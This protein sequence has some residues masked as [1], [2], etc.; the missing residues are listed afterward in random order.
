MDNDLLKK[1]GFIV[2]DN[3]L[4][5]GYPYLPETT[6]ESEPSGWA[7]KTCNEFVSADP[8]VRCVSIQCYKLPYSF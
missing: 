6:A 3:A 8:R 5:G 7:I 1:D 2:F 4:R